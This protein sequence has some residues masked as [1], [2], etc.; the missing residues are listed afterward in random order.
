MSFDVGETLVM[1]AWER[2]HLPV[3]LEREEGY[4]VVGSFGGAGGRQVLASGQPEMVGPQEPDAAV[5]E[6][7]HWPGHSIK[8][9]LA[10]TGG[11]GPH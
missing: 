10:P 8:R 6:L 1:G 7:A 11:A 9:T 5:G 2:D 3:Q 4:T